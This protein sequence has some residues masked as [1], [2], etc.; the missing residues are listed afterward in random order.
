MPLQSPTQKREDELEKKLQDIKTKEK[1][2]KYAELAE[3]FGLPFSTLKGVPIEAD[4]LNLLNEETAKNSNLV[5]LYKTES[6]IVV[7]LINPEDPE[8]QKTLDALKKKYAVDVL[9]TTPEAL[10]A[11]L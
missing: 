1:E 10:N 4:S 5:V 2:G 7:A 3:K 9:L 6:K 8:T 11:V